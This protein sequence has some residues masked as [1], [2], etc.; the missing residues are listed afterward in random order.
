MSAVVEI[1]LFPI[2]YWAWHKVRWFNTGFVKLCNFTF[3]KFNSYVVEPEK[4]IL[5]DKSRKKSW[6]IYTEKS[7]NLNSFIVF[8]I[9][10]QGTCNYFGESEFKASKPFDINIES[11][12][13][14]CVLVI[15]QNNFP[16]KTLICA[17]MQFDKDKL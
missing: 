10:F 2:F 17:K 14:N 4:L 15:H 8:V 12:W 16:S 5:A 1:F 11:V 9:K 6:W 7:W 13:Q 3:D